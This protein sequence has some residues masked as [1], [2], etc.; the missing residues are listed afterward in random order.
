VHGAATALERRFEHFV[1]DYFRPGGVEIR[2]GMTVFDVGANIGLFSLEVLRRCGG[3]ARI[4]AFEPATDTFSYL[5]RNL[6]ELFPDVPVVAARK[7]VANRSGT[8]TFYQRPLA[9]GTSSLRP[10]L[11]IAAD[12]ELEASLREPPP[13][14]RS[15]IPGWFRHLPR[16]VAKAVL[17]QGH[18]PADNYVVSTPCAVTTLADVI[19]EHDIDRIDYLKIDVEGAELDVLR[20]IAGDDWS[21]IAQ[22]GAEVHDIDGRPTDDPRDARRRRIRRRERRPGL[23]VR[24]HE[25]LHAARSPDLPPVMET[26]RRR[27]D[28]FNLP[29][30]H[31]RPVIND[32]GVVLG[33][34]NPGSNVGFHVQLLVGANLLTRSQ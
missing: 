15:Q 4:F 18:R 22:L 33:G 8:A 26:R 28:Q 30:S 6:R 25:H 2:A 24:G 5:E 20:G 19:R 10:R 16:G 7:A 23:A 12:S 11:P 29:R 27:P 3:A 31:A 21:R 14:Y 34:L 1:G 13:E 17:R 32:H 9:S